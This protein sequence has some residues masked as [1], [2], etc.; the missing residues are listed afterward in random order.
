MSVVYLNGEYFPAAD[1][2]VSVFDR[3]FLLGDGVYE[4]IP[5]YAG[6][7]F[8]L[9]HHLDRLQTS[10]DAIRLV[11]P[12]SRKQWE[13]LLNKL[14]AHNYDTNLSVYLQVTRGAAAR[15]HAFPQQTEPTVFAMVN[16]IHPPASELYEKG[17]AAITVE[18]NRW[19]RCDIKSISLLANV[20]LRQQA[21]DQQAA[22]AI[23][24]RN[25]RVTEGAASNVFAVVDGEIR[26]PPKSH[27][28]L[29]GITRDLVLELAAEHAMPHCECDISE[30]DLLHASEVWCTSSTKEIVPVTRLNENK[31]GEGKPG[32]VWQ[33]MNAVYREFKDTLI[34]AG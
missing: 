14:V 8:R 28:I 3:G 6:N 5:A 13:T 15:D 31:V 24:I 16:P 29:P 20:L 33:K 21:V 25:G 17:V 18:D 12:L 11:N 30:S 10:L 1:A 32:P 19:Q 4:V 22:E 23:L 9:E 2:R 27:Y 26:T 7:L 34:N